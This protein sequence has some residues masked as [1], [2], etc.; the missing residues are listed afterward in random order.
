MRVRVAAAALL[1]A[2]PLASGPAL[3][4]SPELVVVET[5]FSRTQAPAGGT[6]WLRRDG[7]GVEDRVALAGDDAY[8]DVVVDVVSRTGDSLALRVPADAPAGARYLLPPGT[9]ADDDRLWVQAGAFVPVDGDVATPDVVVD[10]ARRTLAQNAWGGVPVPLLPCTGVGVG[11]VH[12]ANVADVTVAVPDDVVLDLEIRDEGDAAFEAATETPA[13]LPV[14]A[15]S[16]AS[17]TKTVDRRGRSPAFAVHARFRRIVDAAVG[18]TT[19]VH[20]SVD[21]A[22]SAYVACLCRATAAAATGAPSSAIAVLALATVVGRRRRR[23]TARS[24]RA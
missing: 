16:S 2:A 22:P 11:V 14:D 19:T 17:V 21:P 8:E 15:S 13:L 10:V 9:S 6:W 20:T 7:G 24:A 5:P 3:P 12:D 23:P 18:A 4:C 1:V